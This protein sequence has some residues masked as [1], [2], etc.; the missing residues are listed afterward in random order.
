MTIGYRRLPSITIQEQERFWARVRK[1][2]GQGPNGDCWE[3]Q[4]YR[5]KAGY[6]TFYIR[7][8]TYPKKAGQGHTHFTNRIAYFLQTGDEPFGFHVMHSCD[9]PACV[10]GDHLSKG[11][12]KE[13]TQDAKIKGRL[14][15]GDRAGSRRKPESLPRGDNHWTRRMP[16]SVSRVGSP[17]KISDDDVRAIR[18]AVGS[19]R[20]IASRFNISHR[21]VSNIQS[22]RSRG[23][24]K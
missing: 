20:A 13:N 22:G 5:V 11:T 14:A 21:Q 12:P 2:P 18:A 19:Q 15:S 23:S 3:W 24:V 1:E 16:E 8:E 9:N 4:G 10:R 6:G 17:V 7:P